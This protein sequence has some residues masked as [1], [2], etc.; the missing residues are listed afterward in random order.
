MSDC[1]GC[2]CL[3]WT[4]KNIGSD[5]YLVTYVCTET[6]SAGIYI[7]RKIITKDKLQSD[8]IKQCDRPNWCY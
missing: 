5:D 2:N 1:T 8:E 4:Y 7:S 6:V 3:S